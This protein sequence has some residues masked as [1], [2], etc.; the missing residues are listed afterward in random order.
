MDQDLLARSKVATSMT[1]VSLWPS[2]PKHWHRRPQPNN[3]TRAT[4][5]PGEGQG[6]NNG[7][8]KKGIVAS[9]RK[10][11][12]D[13]TQGPGGPTLGAWGGAGTM[14][15]GIVVSRG[16][17][18]ITKLGPPGGRERVGGQQ[19]TS[20][21]GKVVSRRKIQRGQSQGPWGPI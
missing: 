14:E 6:A 7:P 13:Q 21:K 18:Q 1:I 4:C 11:Q 5:G 15:K 12:R 8:R 17:S 3:Q 19:W 2:G 9:S 16:L 10:I 20:G